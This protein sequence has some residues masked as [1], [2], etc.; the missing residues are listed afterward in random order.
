MQIGDRYRWE[1]AHGETVDIEI[2]TDS[3]A[4]PTSTTDPNRPAVPRVMVRI[5]T[6]IYHDTFALVEPSKLSKIEA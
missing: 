1:R 4:P 5:L 3:I 2:A 6:G